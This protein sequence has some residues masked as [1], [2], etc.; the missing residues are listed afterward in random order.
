MS[1]V[2]PIPGLDAFSKEMREK[3]A[4]VDFGLQVQAFLRSPIGQYLTKRAADEVEDLTAALKNH[5]I[6]G[7]PTGAKT[8]QME[9][10]SAENVLYWLGEA[11]REGSTLMEQMMA[12]ERQALGLDGTDGRGGDPTGN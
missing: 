7:D 10:R 4:L 9:I 5:D 3:L 6:L 1:D 2:P 12:E 11:V 8:I